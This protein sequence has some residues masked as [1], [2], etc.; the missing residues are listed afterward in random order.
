M[1]SP[2]PV[3]EVLVVKFGVNI[4]ERTSSAI[5]IPLSA[6][7]MTTFESLMDSFMTILGILF[8]GIAC[9]AFKSRFVNN[10][11]IWVLSASIMIFCG[12]SCWMIWDWSLDAYKCNTVC[13]ASFKSNN[14]FFGFSIFANWLNSPAIWFRWSICSTRVRA[15]LSV[16][17]L[18]FGALLSMDFWRNCMLSFIGVSGF[19]ISWATCLA[20]SRQAPSRSV[21]TSALAL[22]SSL[23]TILL[24]SATRVPNSSSRFHSMYSFRFS[25]FIF[26]ILSLI[27]EKDFVILFVMNKATMPA[28]KKIKAFRLIMVTRK[29]DI[30]FFKL[31]SEVK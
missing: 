10:R 23:L 21:L 13:N 18:I 1:A 2:R 12:K 19:F 24:Y 31:L 20:I 14:S 7:S 6:I 8:S 9:N 4:L 16:S 30:S 28:I 27:T 3:P 11:F 25:R 15:V 26:F 22:S 17:C 5:P 29:F